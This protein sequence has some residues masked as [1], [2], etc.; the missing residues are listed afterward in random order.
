M[1][2]MVFT[3]GSFEI[4]GI[5]LVRKQLSY[6]DCKPLI[7][8][9]QRCNAFPRKAKEGF[10]LQGQKSHGKVSLFLS[11]AVDW[12]ERSVTLSLFLSR[13]WIGL[14]LDR[15]YGEYSVLFVVLAGD[16]ILKSL[17]DHIRGKQEIPQKAKKS[18]EFLELHEKWNF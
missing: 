13:R 7:K 16:F 5:P 3:D 1:I 10:R 4:W 9:E 17:W 14:F 2:L 12:V 8:L 6:D 11:K 15:M 18:T